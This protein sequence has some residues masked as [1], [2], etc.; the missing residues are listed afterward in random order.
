MGDNV[1]DWPNDLTADAVAEEE[2]SLF[3]A[4]IEGLAAAT[5]QEELARAALDILCNHFGAGSGTLCL[6]RRDE[7]GDLLLVPA[8]VVGPHSALLGD[9]P[10][11]SVAAATDAGEVFRSGEPLFVEDAY[12]S[13]S[14]L[15]SNGAARWRDQLVAQARAV[16]PIENVG[17]TFGTLAMEWSA[18]RQ[19]SPVERELLY[20]VAMLIGLGLAYREAA[21]DAGDAPT[22]AQSV[23]FGLTPEGVVTKGE[24]RAAQS[25]QPVRITAQHTEGSWVDVYAATPGRVLLLVASLGEP[26]EESAALEALRH[27]ARVIAA[28][29]TAADVAISLDARLRELAPAHAFIDGWVGIRGA[30]GALDVA[31]MG[32]SHVRLLMADGRQL[33]LDGPQKDLAGTRPPS[34][35]W[36]PLPGDVLHAWVPESADMRVEW[37]PKEA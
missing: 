2:R 27:T 5:T 7:S 21:P 12:S 36:L 20:C 4:F 25:S 1:G 13:D 17:R 29:G 33:S 9:L 34:A 19:F 3:P 10:P 18:P 14:T 23:A 6:A 22:P 37:V 31:V 35:T 24:G 16:V 8:A 28:R 15:E 26:S 32:T 30:D 11:V